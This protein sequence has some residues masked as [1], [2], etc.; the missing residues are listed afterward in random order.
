MVPDTGILVCF[1]PPVLADSLFI[2]LRDGSEGL[3]VAID[4]LQEGLEQ[5]LRID[6]AGDDPGVKLRLLAFGVELAEIEQELDSVVPDLEV[7][8][9]PLYGLSR[10]LGM[11]TN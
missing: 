1:H 3:F 11:F 6:R 9:I 10:L 4:G 8:C 5:G 2:C 7:I